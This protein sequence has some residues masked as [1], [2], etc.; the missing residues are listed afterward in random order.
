MEREGIARGATEERR[1]RRVVRSRKFGMVEEVMEVGGGREVLGVV[2]EC[3]SVG[4]PF[5]A[6]LQEGA[7]RVDVLVGGNKYR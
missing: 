3:L 6:G 7:Q 4:A 2:A 1:R 5:I